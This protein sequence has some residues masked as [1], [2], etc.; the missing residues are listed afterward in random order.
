VRKLGGPHL[1]MLNDPDAMELILPSL[2]ADYRLVER[3]RP[4][5]ASRVRIPI[6]AAG[7]DSDPEISADDIRAW[8]SATT[9]TFDCRIF[10]GDHFYLLEHGPEL[11]AAALAHV[12]PDVPAR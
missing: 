7:G 6:L 2:R 11:A 1:H 8:E 12:I 10:P 4:D 9:S 3:Y 5:P